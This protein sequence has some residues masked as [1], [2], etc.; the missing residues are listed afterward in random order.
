M[1]NPNLF[2]LMIVRCMCMYAHQKLRTCTTYGIQR[3]HAVIFVAEHP[4][5][6][7]TPC[8]V[9]NEFIMTPTERI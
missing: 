7:N 2:S 5:T 8:D 9:R 6:T 1:D 3:T 4:L